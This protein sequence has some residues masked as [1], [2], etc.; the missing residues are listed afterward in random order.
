MPENSSVHYCTLKVILN[1]NRFDPSFLYLNIFLCK[2]ILQST[3]RNELFITVYPHCS[4]HY[5]LDVVTVS[6]E[7]LVNFIIFILHNFFTVMKCN[8]SSISIVDTGCI[9]AL[10]LNFQNEKVYFLFSLRLPVKLKLTQNMSR[11]NY[12]PKNNFL[13]KLFPQHCNDTNILISDK[14]EYLWICLHVQLTAL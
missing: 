5:A 8:W 10:P 11:Q 2:F 9:S 3:T 14:P 6:Y 13:V 7:R 1:F 4:L 12:C